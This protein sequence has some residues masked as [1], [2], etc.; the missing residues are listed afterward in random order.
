MANSPRDARETTRAVHDNTAAKEL[1]ADSY[2]QLGYQAEGPQWRN[3]F[4]TAAKELRGGIERLPATVP[5]IDIVLG[6]PLSMLFDY[7]AIRLNGPDAVAHPA[8][9]NLVISDM[10]GDHSMQVRNG[11]LHYWPRQLDEV[12]GTVTLTH[13]ALAVLLFT[14]DMYDQL[15]K[16]GQVT[17]DGDADKFTAFLGLLDTFDAYFN[18]V[19]PVATS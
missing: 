8:T 16:A 17:V 15:A 6:M 7:A 4:L 13:Q 9:F 1:A 14:S 5:T 18:I 3:C 11:V 19:T 2:E 12:D 10:D